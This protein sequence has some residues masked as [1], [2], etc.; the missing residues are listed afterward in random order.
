MEGRRREGARGTAWRPALDWLIRC[1]W[2]AAWREEQLL[3]ELPQE[4]LLEEL[5]EQLQLW[6]HRPQTSP[7]AVGRAL[8]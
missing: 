1:S 6:R 5:E 3:E 8:M 2:A 7:Q 4:Q